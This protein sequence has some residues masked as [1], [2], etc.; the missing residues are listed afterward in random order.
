MKIERCPI[1][2]GRIA[3]PSIVISAENAIGAAVI[4]HGYGGSKEEQMGLAWRIAEIGITSIAID[5]RGHGEHALRMDD[6]VLSDVEAAIEYGQQFGKVAA[7]GH[8]LGG[9]LAL[10]SKADYV[11]AISPALK[12]EYSDTTQ[13]TLENLRSHRVREMS[14]G[15]IF[16]VL[17]QLPIW[18]PDPGRKVFVLYGERDVPEIIESCWELKTRGVPV[19]ELDKAMHGDTFLTEAAFQHITNQLEEWCVR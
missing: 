9:R 15:I 5:L 2:N 1:Q 13:K 18:Y 19:V 10:L 4:I 6:Q 16:K 14:P 11:I 12:Q 7:I 3:I 17:K 8:S